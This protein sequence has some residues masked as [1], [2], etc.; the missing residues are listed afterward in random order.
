MRSS[1]LLLAFV[2]STAQPALAIAVGGKLYVKSK[3]T[4]LL[5]DPKA[6]SAK[7]STL[8]P[9]TEVTWKGASAKDKHFQEVEAAGKKGFVLTSNLTPHQ[10]QQEIDGSSGKP[11]SG[12]SFASSGASTKGPFGPSHAQSGGS[13]ATQETAAELIYVEELNKAKAT[14]QALEAQNKA[15]H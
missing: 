8:Q 13:P 3:D 1:L 9:G 12:Q 14:P 11:M 2:V 10:P 7:V 6:S 5:K 4:P 15:L